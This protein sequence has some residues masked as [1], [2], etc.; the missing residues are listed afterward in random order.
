M[1][2][3][4]SCAAHAAARGEPLYA[5]ASTVRRW[6]LLEQPG[7]WGRDALTESRIPADVADALARRSVELRARIVLIRRHGREDV[8]R[9][10]HA[11]YVGVSG[12]GEPWL[13]RHE[14]D[15]VE[16]LLRLDLSP[17]AHGERTGGVIEAMP[18]Y[19]TC[20]NGAHDAC[21]AE[22]GRPLA[23]ALDRLRPDAAWECSHI[24]GDRFAANLV[25]FPHGAYFG[26]VVPDDALRVVD[27]YEQRRLSLEHYRG[28][29]C[30]AFTVQAA[31]H[32]VRE[33]QGLDG[34]DD[35]RFTGRSAVDEDQVRVT[36]EDA[37]GR[38]WAVLLE[39]H[40][41]PEGRRLTCRS[42][43]PACPPRYAVLDYGAS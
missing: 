20:T 5:T 28:R 23:A 2:D 24:G 40:P 26:R 19:L 25:C 13:E 8:G 39:T 32:F 30:F 33:R 38:R 27:L 18:L 42:Q 35:L 7:S 15:S 6:I 16:D 14:L 22:Y 31:E 10:G 17:L 9:S 12:P 34:L 29:S 37:E 21:C 43:G 41:D 4:F 11:C 36:F 1:N 3:R